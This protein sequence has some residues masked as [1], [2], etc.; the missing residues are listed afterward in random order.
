MPEGLGGPGGTVQPAPVRG[1]TPGFLRPEEV[2]WSALGPEFIETWGH[3][4]EGKI[5]AEHWEVT[6]QSG[7]GKSYL[8]AT[9][10]QQR[11]ERWDTPE[12][13]CLTKASDDS[14]PLLGWPEVHDYKGLKQF[15]QALFWPRTELKGE[16]REKWHEQR[17]YELLS[18]LWQ[19][20]ANVVLYFDE[21]RYIES[22]SNR[23]KKLVRMYWREGRSHGISLIA[24]AQ[25]P[26]EMVRDQHSES[27]WKAVFPP[28]DE[29]DMERF[30][31]LLGRK[32]DWEPVLRSL[33][34]Q[35]HQFVLRNN[36]SKVS[37]I[38]WVD[39][40]L[41]PLPSQSARQQQGPTAREHMYGKRPAAA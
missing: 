3:D 37:Y 22:L 13:A 35:Q 30:S 12:I 1:G 34:Q 38:T 16:Q 40:K 6:G 24:G 33:D 23:L 28:A 8:I 11:A 15:R 17:L 7:G 2:P 14:L 29:A 39:Q 18:E 21:V 31:Q 41:R 9:A 10:L 27:R 25:R 19:P 36:V 32:Q 4:D 20:D 26:V 5:K